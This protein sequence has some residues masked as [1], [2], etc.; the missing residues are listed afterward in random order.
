M[1]IRRL[2]AI[3][4]LQVNGAQFKQATDHLDRFAQNANTVMSAV[5]GHVVFQALQNFVTNTAN[6]M[7]E[8][9]KTAGYLGLTTE[10]LQELR[11]AAEKSGVSLDTLDDSL[12][13]LMIRS[14]DAK[15]GAGEAAE[16]FAAL[17]LKT[18]D[19]AGRMREPLEL[20]DEV[21]DRLNTLPTQSDRIWVV[22]SMFGDQGAQMLKMLKDGSLGLRSMRTEARDLG[23]VLDSDAISKASRFS[24]ALKRMKPPLAGSSIRWFRV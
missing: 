2:E 17:G 13:E 23:L 16:A 20:L 12:K 9:G 8:V 14:V 15:S 18:T 10:A 22:D 3:F 7:A 24:Q 11:Y 19:A 5:A 4:G 1:I 6:T 21:A